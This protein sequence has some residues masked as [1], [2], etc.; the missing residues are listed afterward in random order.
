MV[1][2]Q[3]VVAPDS[4]VP[5]V[6][7]LSAFNGSSWSV[8]TVATLSTF[9]ASFA[10]AQNDVWVLDA[11]LNAHWNGLAWTTSAGSTGSMTGA[12]GAA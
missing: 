11:G 5:N 6:G 8:T 10:F 1:V 9:T 7:S 12:Y 4:L 3:V 2:D